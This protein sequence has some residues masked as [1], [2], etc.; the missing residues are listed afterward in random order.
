MSVLRLLD[1][2]VCSG[3]LPRL[4]QVLPEAV[5]RDGYRRAHVGRAQLALQPSREGTGADVV[6]GNCQQR[7]LAV[8]DAGGHIT[9]LRDLHKLTGSRK[10]ATP[11][12]RR[13][14]PALSA[15][16]APGQPPSSPQ[17]Q[18]QHRHRRSSEYR[19]CQVRHAR[20]QEVRLSD[21][22][23][24]EGKVSAMVLATAGLTR[25]DV[26][27]CPHVAPVSARLSKSDEYGPLDL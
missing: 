13:A 7:E 17:R 16:E 10:R 8:L 2:V 18:H 9:G 21:L 19:V 15:I 5:G 25:A 26:Q 3:A 27:Q 14:G 11:H 24:I 23:R 1:V 22:E 20:R 12:D 4:A 6:G